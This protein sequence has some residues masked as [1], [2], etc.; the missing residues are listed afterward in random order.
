MIDV[1]LPQLG[2]TVDEA[3]LT[4]WLKK[5]GDLVERDEPLLE[6]TTDKVTVE[7]PS[8]HNGIL[9]EILLS[10]GSKV[11]QQDIICRIEET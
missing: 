5:V 9:R 11:T 4:T 6:V 3:L 7:V 2:D 10:E 1:K 8:E